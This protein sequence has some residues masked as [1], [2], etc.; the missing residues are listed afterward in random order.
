MLKSASFER[1]TGLKGL[2]KKKVEVKKKLKMTKNDDYP[3]HTPDMSFQ[4]P[5]IP[6]SGFL[7]NPF[8]PCATSGSLL[9]SPEVIGPSDRS[10]LY[11]LTESTSFLNELYIA[12]RKYIEINV[13][14]VYR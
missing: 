8:N 2:N 11:K 13:Y 12:S 9:R 3:L 14:F 4:T 1:H 7:F 5:I 6:T 10:V